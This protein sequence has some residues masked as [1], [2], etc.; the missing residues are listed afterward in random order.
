MPR[1]ADST[2]LLPE[3]GHW[4]EYASASVLPNTAS[5]PSVGNFLN[6][7]DI[8]SVA[9]E[10]YVCT[11]TV[12]GSATWSEIIH[13]GSTSDVALTGAFSASGAITPT[14]GIVGTTLGRVSN[15]PIG[16]VA[17]GSLGTDT[18]VGGTGT[19]YFSE[20]WLPSNKTCTGAA[21]LNGTTAG[22]DKLILGLAN[23]AGT[24]VATTALAGTTA[25]GTDAFQSIAFTAPYAAVGPAK[26][27]LIVQVNGNTTKIRT[28]AASTYLNFGNSAAGTFGTLTAITPATDAGTNEGPI[29]F[30]YT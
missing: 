18:T 17:Y 26:Y 3:G 15:I 14:G 7:G 29:G 1:T 19:T 20:I 22:T 24:V 9:G 23:A 25:S 21:V 13:A 16:G 4:G 11:S 10:I 8:A 28:I 6:R 12:V 5:G 2:K 27:W 30:V